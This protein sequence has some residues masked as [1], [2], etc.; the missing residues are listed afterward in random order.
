MDIPEIIEKFIKNWAK[1]EEFYLKV[2]KASNINKSDF[3]FTFSPIDEGADVEG[4]RMKVIEDGTNESFIIIP[5]DNTFVVVAFHNDTTAQCVKVQL[6]DEI[7]VNTELFLFNN[8]DNE[9]LV[10]INELTDKLNKLTDEVNALVNKFNTHTHPGVTSGGAST[11]VP[12]A[13]AQTVTAFNKSDYE[14]DKIKH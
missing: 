5:K 3:T 10:K 11:S 9:G 12:I 8:G 2:G 4:V 1:K 14:N 13:Q 7:I 6:S